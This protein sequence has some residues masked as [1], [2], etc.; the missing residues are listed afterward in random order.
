MRR[1]TECELFV[2]Q[3]QPNFPVLFF[4]YKEDGITSE[5]IYLTL[6][7]LVF[8]D[9][10]FSLLQFQFHCGLKSGISKFEVCLQAIIGI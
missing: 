8:R 7:L 4:M 10:T 6:E 9:I 5:Y 2:S 1:S 3:K